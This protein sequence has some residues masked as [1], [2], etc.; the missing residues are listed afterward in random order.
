M[1]I[2]VDSKP[3]T[4]QEQRTLSH[5]PNE[6]C[7]WRDITVGR[8][9]K[10]RVWSLQDAGGNLTLKVGGEREA[11]VGACCWHGTN[12]SGSIK[13]RKATVG[14]SGCTK[15]FVTK[16]DVQSQSRHELDVVLEEDREV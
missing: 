13:V 4:Q 3:P 1:F 10:T 11:A 7:S 2:E 8:L 9:I 12:R 15:Y 14:L 6:A 5:L 16:P